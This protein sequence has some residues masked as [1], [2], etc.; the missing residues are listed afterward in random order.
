MCIILCKATYTCQSV[1]FTTLLI[2]ANRTELSQAQRQILIWTRRIF[3]N[4]TV[5]RTVHRFQEVLLSFF[6]CMN[7]LEWILT[8]FSIVTRSYI[9]Q[10]VT[11][12]RSNNL[13]IIVTCL[14]TAQELLQ[15]Q[16]QCSTFRQPHRQSFTYRIREHEQ[17]HFPTDFAMVTFFG[18]FQN[19]QI[20]I[21]HLFL[22]ESN[23]VNTRHHLAVFMSTPVSTGYRHQFDSLNRC[24]SHQVR[25]TAQIRKSTLRISSNVTILQFRDQFTFISFSTITEF[26]QCIRFWN[27]FSH[28]SFFL[29]Y[30]FCHFSLNHRKVRFFNSSLTRI[31]I[32]VET[33]FNGRTNTELNTRI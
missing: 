31:H 10:L 27:T 14:N 17:I 12:R 15:T 25:A 20:F 19:N 23:T 13:L 18:F 29:C 33:V 1:Q 6:G 32:I 28:N 8:I 22:R 21:Q 5:V 30:Q 2:T 11:N 7:R 24:S 4:H 3:I 16:T 26:C 9:Q